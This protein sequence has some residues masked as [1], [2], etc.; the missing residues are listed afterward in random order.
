MKNTGQMI[1]DDSNNNPKYLEIAMLKEKIGA[2]EMRL[3]QLKSNQ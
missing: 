3:K 2:D 1:M